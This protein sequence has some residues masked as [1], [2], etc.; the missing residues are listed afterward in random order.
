[1]P[2]AGVGQPPNLP[3]SILTRLSPSVLRVGNCDRP[4]DVACSRVA[5]DSWLTSDS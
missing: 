4:N 3:A 2:A 1:M 5:T